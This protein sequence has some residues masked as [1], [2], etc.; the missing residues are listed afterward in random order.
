MNNSQTKKIAII[1]GAVLVL[2][3]GGYF[4]INH[5]LK[6]EQPQPNTN[7]NLAT[8][9][10]DFQKLYPKLPADHRFVETNEN[11]ILAKFESGD[12]LIFLGF[13]ECP[14]CQALA[15]IVDEA[16][17]AEN[18]DKIYYLNIKEAR[19]HN[20]ETYQKLIKKLEPLLN[21]DDK[22]QPR[23]YV[24][25]V[26]AVK[27]GKIV[28][29]FLQETAPDGEKLTPDNYWTDARYSRAVKQFREMIQQIKDS[30]LT[31][32]K[33]MQDVKKGAVVIDVRTTEEYQAGHVDGATLWPLSDIQAGKN[34]LSSQVNKDTK[35]Y[36]YCRSGNRS[37]T[38]QQLLQKQ[39]YTNV[40]DLGGLGDLTKLGFSLV[41]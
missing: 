39:G 22:G 33:I 28:G 35:I 14:W 23:I 3:V 30:P 31:K 16:A 29:H 5:F 11:E 7:Q 20:T 9:R 32:E 21:K 13:T 40:V 4:I 38:A 6:K 17:K 26:T 34:Q 12:G 2:A 19:A 15:P 25:D 10:A 41:K 18:L 24:P 37:A 36:L 1:V 27:K 8:T